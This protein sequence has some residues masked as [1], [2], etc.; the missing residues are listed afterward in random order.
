M[1]K[2]EVD[3]ALLV[4]HVAYQSAALGRAAPITQSY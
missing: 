2:Q 4:W 3:K 1:M